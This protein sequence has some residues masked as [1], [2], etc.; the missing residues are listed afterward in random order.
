[1]SLG[2]I[3]ASLSVCTTLV[4]AS[5]FLARAS[6]AVGAWLSTPALTLTLSG[7]ALTLPL[8]VMVMVRFGASCSSASAAGESAGEAAARRAHRLKRA[9]R[10]FK[11]MGFPHAVGEDGE[12]ARNPPLR[13]SWR[14]S[15]LR[16]VRAREESC[17][18]AE[19]GRGGPALMAKANF[20]M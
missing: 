3:P 6:L 1:M 14:A 5:V 4:I 8:P 11:V 19:I 7:A 16:S 2:S 20:P 15:R 18:E 13:G 9:L 10:S 12:P 17:Y